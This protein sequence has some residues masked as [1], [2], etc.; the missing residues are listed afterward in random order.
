[1]KNVKN[2]YELEQLAKE[3]G[4]DVLCSTGL[5]TPE[6]LVF[7]VDDFDDFDDYERFTGKNAHDKAGEYILN[8]AKEGGKAF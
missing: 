4:F 1:M 8:A 5:F 2:N 7:P 3:N 6:I